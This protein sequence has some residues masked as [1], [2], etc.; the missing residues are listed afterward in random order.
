MSAC[1]PSPVQQEVD[2]AL[3]ELR[4]AREAREARTAREPRCGIETLCPDDLMRPCVRP[5]DHDGWHDGGR[6]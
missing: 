4:Q 3:R 2:A 5:H 6:T 1:Y